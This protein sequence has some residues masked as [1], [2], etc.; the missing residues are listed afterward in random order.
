[1]RTGLYVKVCYLTGTRTEVASTANDRVGLH[2]FLVPPSPFP[3]SWAARL[4]GCAIPTAVGHGYER[5]DDASAQLKG[6]ARMHALQVRAQGQYIN[7]KIDL[8]IE[9]LFVEPFQT[10]FRRVFKHEVVLHLM[11]C[12]EHARLV[13]ANA[14]AACLF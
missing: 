11:I 5:C 8:L 2:S 4:Y 6:L 12:T 3:A 7:D 1:M 10:L 13:T 9:Y 14:D